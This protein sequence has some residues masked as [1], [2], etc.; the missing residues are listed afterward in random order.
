MKK[1][2]ILM[3]AMAFVINLNLPAQNIQGKADDLDRITLNA[4]VP[5]QVDE[6]PEAARSYLQNKLTQIA[7]MNG[8]GGVEIN[9]RFV[10]TTGVHV[11]T[12]DITPTAPPKIAYTLSFTL[13]IV[14]AL[15]QKVFASTN[16]EARGVGNNETRAYTE[17]IKNLNVRSP[18]MKNFVET[19]KTKIMEYYNSQCDFI[20]SEANSLAGR[21]EFE[22]AVFKL[23]SI[24]EVSKE[25]HH[26]GMEA[27]EGVYLQYAEYRCEQLLNEAR[28]RWAANMHFAG[29]QQ[30]AELLSQIDPEAGCIPEVNTLVAEIKSRV[31]QVD[32]REWDFNVATWSDRAAL[33]SQRI[34]AIRDI[35]VAWGSRWYRTYNFDLS[36]IWM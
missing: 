6:M 24:P 25:C 28:N 19:G 17:A 22:E 26:L 31:L 11:L 29:A 15:E 3:L 5:E 8:M 36:W 20:I 33:E 16:L 13:Y 35:G 34:S 2:L 10:I 21:K 12:K 1:I 9:P 7:T 18:Q 27:A 32:Q 30:A 4:I 14:D 23:T